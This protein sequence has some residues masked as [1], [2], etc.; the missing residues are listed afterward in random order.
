MDKPQKNTSWRICSRGHKFTG[1]RCTTC[2]KG[3]K[4]LL[5]AGNGVEAGL[6][7]KG[8]TDLF[9]VEKTKT[10]PILSFESQK[11][12]EKWLSKNYSNAD[13]IWLRFFKKGSGVQTVVYAEA[14]DVALCY[15]WIDAQVNKFDELSYRQKFTPRRAK[16][17][18]S[19]RNIEHAERLI[20]DGKMKEAGFAQIEA[21]KKDG[22]WEKA[23]DSPS[24]MVMPEDFLKMVSKNKKAKAFFDTL[25]KA[26]TY[27][28]AWRLQT[29]KKPETRERRMKALLAMLERG[30]KLY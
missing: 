9:V 1:S 16:S 14:L 6:I 27:A 15:G 28:I 5:G 18:W 13:G 11:A 23:Y 26:N 24:T 12:W 22:R 2:W 25:T 8:M 3:S 4:S 20:K 17:I 10:V 7:T 29:A 21:A 19:K 30:E